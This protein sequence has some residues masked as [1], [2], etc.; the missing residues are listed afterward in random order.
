VRWEQGEDKQSTSEGDDSTD[1][2]RHLDAAHERD[3]SSMGQK[4]SSDTTGSA[5]YLEGAAKGAANSLNDSRRQ[6]PGGQCC[7]HAVL[8]SGG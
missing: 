5:R 2:E 4:G 6:V 1:G 3:T 7:V 8:E